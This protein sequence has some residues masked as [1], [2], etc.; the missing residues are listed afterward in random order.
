MDNKC[1]TSFCIKGDFDVDRVI[2][3]LGINPYRVIRH[4][5]IRKADHKAYGF[6]F[7]E[8]SR[9][10]DYD[11][12]VTKMMEKTI[13]PL[14]DKK[15]VLNNIKKEYHVEYYLKVVPHLVVNQINPALGPSLEVID[16]LHDIRG[17][18]DIDLYLY[19]GEDEDEE[20]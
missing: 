9:N 7:L 13:R 5:E 2:S 4:D 12:Y 17:E 1:S 15:D 8:L 18:L 14:L 20:C 6:D 10:E 11:V 19:N 16:F 3:L